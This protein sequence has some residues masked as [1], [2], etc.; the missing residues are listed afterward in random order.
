MKITKFQNGINTI[1]TPLTKISMSKKE[2]GK[3]IQNLQEQLENG[4]PNEFNTGFGMRFQ[5]VIKED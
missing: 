5:F 2:A 3:L 1:F 4:L